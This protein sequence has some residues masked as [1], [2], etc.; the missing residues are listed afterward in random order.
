MLIELIDRNTQAESSVS[1]LDSSQKELFRIVPHI[2]ES[3]YP[4]IYLKWPTRGFA[5]ST[6]GELF[7]RKFPLSTANT[8]QA[9]I[10]NTL[11]IT[12][13]IAATVCDHLVVDRLGTRALNEDDLCSTVPTHRLLE[14]ARLL[15]DNPG[16][17]ELDLLAYKQDYSLQP[18]NE[19]FPPPGLSSYRANGLC[20]NRGEGRLGKTS[21]W[22]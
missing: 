13:S 1:L 22:L 4:S 3:Q 5:K 8:R 21:G 9:I 6:F 14:S 20:R 15:F 17:R 18:L 2:W 10:E 19:D 11:S 12:A 16:P 7:S